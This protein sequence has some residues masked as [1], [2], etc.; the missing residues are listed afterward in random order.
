MPSTPSE[1]NFFLALVDCNNFFVSCEKVF[2]PKLAGL[3]VVVLSNNDGCIVARS[4]EAKAIGIPMGAPLY[5]WEEK[6]ARYG[7]RAISAN[8]SLYGDMSR[9]VM[10]TIAEHHFDHEVYSIDE[11]FLNFT[12]ISRP[13]EHA[14]KLKKTIFQWTGIPVSIGLGKTKVLAK[15]A[16]KRAKKTKGVLGFFT[17]HDVENALRE[18]ASDDLWGIGRRTAH[19]LRSKGIHTAYDFYSQDALWV[20]KHLGVPGQR[21]HLELHGKPCF[22]LDDEPPPK[23]SILTSRSFK[24]HIHNREELLSILLGFTSRA[25]EKLREEGEVAR[26]LHLFLMTS[27]FKDKGP[28]YYNETIESFIK[29]TDFTPNL[30]H[31]A[32]SAFE[33][34]FRPKLAYKRAGIILSGLEPAG[35]T[36]DDLFCPDG[37]KR[38]REKKLMQVMDSVNEHIKDGLTFASQGKLYWSREEACRAYTTSFDDL[39]IIKI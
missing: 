6:I 23:Q 29:P 14:E 21:V 33:K 38:D 17:S 12:G 11:A 20:K 24:T 19:F 3:P 35:S 25:G 22:A 10:R 5:Q 30:L 27:P 32:S 16:N 13:L 36:T 34:I 1:D 39:L 28:F 7:G 9:R 18:M 26:F 31:A 37:K 4:N 15:A 8:F 2:N